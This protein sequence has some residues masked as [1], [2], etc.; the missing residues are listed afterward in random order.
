VNL[1]LNLH[2]S[3]RAVLKYLYSPKQY[4][5]VIANIRKLFDNYQRIDIFVFPG[6]SEL[7]KYIGHPVPA[8]V[9]AANFGNAILL[10]DYEIWK[11]RKCGNVN[12]IIIHEMI[13]VL[14]GNFKAK[15]PVWLDEGLAQYLAG[16]LDDGVIHQEVLWVKSI[17]E[18]NYGHKYFYYLSGWVVKQ[19]IGQHGLHAVISR[20]AKVADYFGDELFGAANINDL[21]HNYLK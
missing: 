16:Q 14:I 9:I 7:I 6:L 10:L 15:V 2:F 21:I 19:L 3:D 12:Q 1:D 5:N 17:Y 4:L 11:K 20:M 18:L 13:H 8:W